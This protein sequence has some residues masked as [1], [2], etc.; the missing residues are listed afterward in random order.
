MKTKCICIDDSKKP[1]E[2]P[3]TKWVKKDEEYNIVYIFWHPKQKVQGVL[4]SEIELDDSCMPYASYMLKRFA[5][6]K[7]NI[8]SLIELCKAC[9]EMN[10]VDITSL[11][12]ELT[13][14][15]V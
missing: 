1:K 5:F 7:E 6:R 10:D 9:T 15:T 4:L 2:I 8:A 11:G 3:T 14:E 13:M 12:E